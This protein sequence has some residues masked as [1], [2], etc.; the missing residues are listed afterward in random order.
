MQNYEDAFESA[1]DDLSLQEKYYVAKSDRRALAQRILQLEDLLRR[2]NA[3][4]GRLTNR[5]DRTE[6]VHSEAVHKL[7]EALKFY[8]NKK[9]YRYQ[10]NDDGEAVSPIG[11]DHGH[12]A[13]GVLYHYNLASKED[14]KE[15]E[16]DSE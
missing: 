8:A 9:S 11:L 5:I 6:M 16:A 14:R 1:D 13:K 2:A 12:I 4:V 3:K 15:I 7:R 10:M